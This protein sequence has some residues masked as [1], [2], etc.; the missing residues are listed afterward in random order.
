MS[1]I[2]RKCVLL[3]FLCSLIII[4]CEKNKQFNGKSL[5]QN[6]EI[7]KLNES[8]NESTIEKVFILPNKMFV[9]PNNLNLRMLPDIESEIIGTIPVYAMISIIGKNEVIETIDNNES[10][11]FNVEYNENRGWVF[12]AY[13][14]EHIDISQFLIGYWCYYNRTFWHTNRKGVSIEYKDFGGAEYI[15]FNKDGT[16]LT[17]VTNYK[18]G[19]WKSFDL[20]LV[21]D[22]DE[23]CEIDII[24][25]NHVIFKTEEFSEV[26]LLS[27]IYMRQNNELIEILNSNNIT[28]L[29]KYL[30][31][32]RDINERLHYDL[33][34]L[35]YAILNK[36]NEVALYLIER[37]ADLSLKDI[38]GYTALFYAAHYSNI[39]DNLLQNILERDIE[40]NALDKYNQT[41]LDSMVIE[42]YYYNDNNRKILK[43]LTE[44][45]AICSKNHWQEE[46]FKEIRKLR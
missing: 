17:D 40:I 5:E 43:I 14:V 26:I 28:K 4:C 35:M 8:T 6:N 22:F 12:G 46:I 41:I 3:L 38:S 2:M 1:I 10:Y 23:I 30:D 33:T 25:Q 44:Y 11:W 27:N 42:D 39:D 15:C 20:N 21:F 45:G 37:V 24:D 19:N 13:L 9:Y 7:L 18:T 32:G 34:P 31:S 16:Y 36:K 29:K